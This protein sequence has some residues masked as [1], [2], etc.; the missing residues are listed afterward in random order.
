[1]ASD[2]P[3]ASGWTLSRNRSS[4]GLERP[5]PPVTSL[6]TVHTGVRLSEATGEGAPTA[7]T[8]FATQRSS[9]MSEARTF[10]NRASSALPFTALMARRMTRSFPTVQLQVPTTPRTEQRT[11]RLHRPTPGRARAEQPGKYEHASVPGRI[12]TRR[13]TFA[14][15]FATA[16]ERVRPVMR[17]NQPGSQPVERPEE[18]TGRSVGWEQLWRR[19]RESQIVPAPTQ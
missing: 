8:E 4:C 5:Q 3:R 6:A 9:W 10:R 15:W 18:G 11:V 12:R 1:V 17:R 7:G 13:F 14:W 16:G 19:L 2:F